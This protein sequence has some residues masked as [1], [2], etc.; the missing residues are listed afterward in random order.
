MHRLSYTASVWLLE[1][2]TSVSLHALIH[3]D[4]E[5]VT[6]AISSWER[7]CAAQQIVDNL[8]QSETAESEYVECPKCGGAMYQARGNWYHRSNQATFCPDH[9]SELERKVVEAAIGYHEGRAVDDLDDAVEALLAATNPPSLE[10]QINKLR[11]DPDHSPP[12]HGPT[13]WE[14]IAINQNDAIDRI[15]AL[16]KEHQHD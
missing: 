5:R 8:E 12:S 14:A 15:L 2:T 11:L 16:I 4:G 10:E 13:E 7:L 9:E 1:I 3:K 6:L